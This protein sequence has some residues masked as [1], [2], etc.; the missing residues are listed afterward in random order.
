MMPSDSPADSLL[1]SQSNSYVVGLIASLF[2]FAGLSLFFLRIGVERLETI[3]FA[4]LSALTIG[5]FVCRERVLVN[6][7]ATVK[8]TQAE[9]LRLEAERIDELYSNSV[10][11]LAIFDAGTLM[12]DRVSPGFFD[13]LD[14]SARKDL[15]GEHIEEVLGVDSSRFTSLVYQM[16]AGT[17]RIREEIV[18]K[19]ADG[20]SVVLLVSGRYMPHLHLIEAAFFRVHR[21]AATLADYE[22]VIDD[23]ERFKKGIV[24]RESRVLE[25]KGEVNQLL[26]QAG[27]PLRYQVDS[28][29]DDSRF[30]QNKLKIQRAV[31]DE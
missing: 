1:P 16:K 14:I 30:V 29:S 6:E 18:C 3:V 8:R 23:L 26:N 24:R 20:K 11:C 17:M 15:V 7:L 22:R 12:I 31:E 4:L 13:L 10:A 9:Q 28:T 27:K 19:Q 25:L 5:G 2:S 21:K